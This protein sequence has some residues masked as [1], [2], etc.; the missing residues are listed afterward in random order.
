MFLVPSDF[1]GE[2]QLG[3]NPLQTTNFQIYINK[4]EKKYLTDLLGVELYNLFI[5]D[6]DVNFYPQLPIYQ[7]IYEE[8]E[9]DSQYGTGCQHRSLGMIEMLKGFIYYHWLRDQF[10]TKTI[11]GAVKNEFS[12]SQPA[13]MSQTNMDEKYNE[14]VCMYNAIKWYINE[15]K[16]DYPD[17]NGIEKCSITWL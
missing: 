15:N 1:T 9:E 7:A 11:S 8:I 4:L 13:T 5:A 16:I 2:Y 6:L 12:N 10:T 3:G 17:Y 14:S